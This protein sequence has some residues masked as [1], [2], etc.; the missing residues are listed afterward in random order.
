MAQLLLFQFL[1]NNTT[2]PAKSKNCGSFLFLNTAA[3][4]KFLNSFKRNG[5]VEH[6]RAVRQIVQVV[7]QLLLRG[8]NLG[9][10]VRMVVVV[11]LGPARKAGLYEVAQ[12]IVRDFFF[13]YLYE[14]RSL[15]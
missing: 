15:W 10:V 9:A 13:V 14:R 12:A 6:K 5:R 2:A 7:R 4:Q 1:T 8:F 3:G 11:D